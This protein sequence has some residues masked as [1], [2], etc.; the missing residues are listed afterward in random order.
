MSG[1]KN[2]NLW[3]G[4]NPPLEEGGGDM[5]RLPQAATNEND[6]TGFL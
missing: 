5:G 3:L 4:F 2:P 1:K 6:Y